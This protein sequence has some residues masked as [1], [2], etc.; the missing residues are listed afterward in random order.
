MNNIE[1]K[2]KPAPT[3]PTH[4]QEEDPYAEREKRREAAEQEQ[5]VIEDQEK[6]V[7]L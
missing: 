2:K 1:K 7:G 4:I 5:E 3:V 6:I